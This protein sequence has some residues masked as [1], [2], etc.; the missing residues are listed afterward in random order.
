MTKKEK[1]KVLLLGG[2][3]LLGY[4]CHK[5]FESTY[6]VI[7]CWNTRS[8][9]TVYSEQIDVLEDGD[10][11]QLL[12]EKYQ[13]QVVI[14]TIGYVTVDGCEQNPDLAKK[15]N[16]DF[17]KKLVNAMSSSG[18][19]NSHL[20]QISTDSVYGNPKVGFRNQPWKE[21]DLLKPL[22]I[23]AQTKLDGENEAKKHK[24]PYSILRTAF[25]GINPYSTKSLLWWI[26]DNAR[27][28][29]PMDGWENIYFSP[30]SA[31]RLS[32]VIYSMIENKITGIYNVSSV[33][34][35]NKYDFVEAVCSYLNIPV[36]I[37]RVSGNDSSSGT[38]RPDYSVLDCSKL[39]EAIP[40]DVN[41]QDDLQDYMQNLPPLP[42]NH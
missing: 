28:G 27:K 8:T 35:C 36:T 39:K 37:N 31:W 42:D 12:M 32:E 16:S 24:G 26:I 41:W 2:S 38:I 25:Y 13:P 15:L 6:K 22:S 21:D 34:A 19:N 9:S 4:H 7:S 11:I 14:N 5:V 18:L 1:P 23:Y 20:I 10:K 29:N 30:V 33:N 40:W 17:V 3:G